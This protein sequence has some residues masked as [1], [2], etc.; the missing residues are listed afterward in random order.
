MLKIWQEIEQKV[1]AGYPYFYLVTHEESRVAANL[2]IVGKR[3]GCKLVK[4]SEYKGFQPEILHEK[5]KSVLEAVL[6]DKSPGIYILNDYH[7]S[8]AKLSVIR[9]IKDNREELIKN[10]QSII[11]TAPVLDLPLELEKYFA[12]IDV[13]LPD[14]Y[15]QKL[16]FKQVANN[17]NVQCDEK[18]AELFA[19]SATGLTAEEAMLVFSRMMLD[20]ELVQAGDTSIVIEEKRRLVESE[21]VL[22][23][24]E[25]AIELKD[26]GGLHSLKDW[27]KEREEAFDE[28][29]R[30]F[31]LPEP[32]GLLLLGVQGCGKSLTAKA[33]ASHWSIPLVQLDLGSAFSGVRS[34]EETIRRSLKLLEALSPV[35][36]W[37][38]EIEKGFAGTKQA[39]GEVSTNRVFGQFITWMQEKQS[40]VFVVAT[41]NSVQELPPE[42]LRKGRFD[43]LFFVDLPDA[44]EREEILN[45]H[46]K[47]RKINSKNIDTKHL[48]ELTRNYS[49]AELEQIV[50]DALYR[51]FADKRRI[52]GDDLELTAK[53]LVPI[54]NTYEEDIKLL[55]DWAKD[56]TR[57]ASIDSTLSD[58]FIKE[59]AD[60]V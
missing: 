8:L 39:G 27:L 2:A 40:P 26:V 4:Y 45:V 35:V 32:K 46:L 57:K 23:F 53:D 10:K 52:T 59:E 25:R 7:S 48:A 22:Q 20:P 37:I 17:N 33:I 18:Q 56:R 12:V 36:V 19:R 55:R 28:R 34:P 38:D 47:K 15:E 21:G 31:G 3:V 44:H 51:A 9:Q 43:E 49:G 42:L 1:K 16:L 14:A 11:L 29:A 24:Y 5:N 50:V 13:P 60:N 41:A 6:A 58:Y 54:Y 30:Q